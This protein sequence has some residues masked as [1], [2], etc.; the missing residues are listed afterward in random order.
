MTSSSLAAISIARF[1]ISK[2]SISN[3]GRCMGLFSFAPIRRR[4][5]STDALIRIFESE[6]AEIREDPEPARL[7]FTLHALAGLFASLL[8]VSV[9]MPMNRVVTSVA[10]EMVTTEPTIVLQALDP[11][12]IKTLDIQEGELVKRGRLLATLDPT[13]TT[14]D[15]SALTLQIASFDA[16]IAR[17]EAELAHR[18]FDPPV[19]TT[20]QD[21]YAALQKAYYVQRKGQF[22]A[23]LQA[24]DEQIAQNRA[25]I[26]K[27]ETD[28]T[29]YDNR[30]KI[31][32]QIEDMRA[33]GGEPVRQPP[34]PAHRHRSAGRDPAQPRFRP[35]RP[36]RKRAPACRD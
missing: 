23:Q 21:A 4:E 7:R 16:Q 26:R 29:H 27:L 24:Y 34:Q 10:G 20:P 9:V 31:N 13:F 30:V 1:G 3:Q 17:T 11:S 2:T 33:S 28:F 6:T 5:P 14:A 36:G 19:G 35:Q 15:V 18:D 32:Q 22:D 12:I 8:A 25:T